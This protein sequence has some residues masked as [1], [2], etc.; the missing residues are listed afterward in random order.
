MHHIFFVIKLLWWDK[1]I[2]KKPYAFLIKRFKIIHLII[3]AFLL[4]IGYRSIQIYNFFN[5]Y[6]LNNY[7]TK[8]TIGLS[9]MY[10][11]KYL[12][13]SILLIIAGVTTIL[14][15][16]LKK[17]KKSLLYILMDVYYVVLFIGFI[18]LSS[19]LSS[20]E[21]ALLASTTARGIRDVLLMV[22][23]PQAIFIFFC[24]LRSIG[25]NIKQFNFAKDLREIEYASA[26]ADEVEISINFE[27]YKA[28]RTLR[29]LVREI[30]YYVKENKF[31]VIC[32]T[33]IIVVVSGYYM[34]THSS[35]SY[36]LNYGV[37]ATFT[38][39]N[40]KINFKE[41]IITNLNYKGKI[42]NDGKYYLVL[43]AGISNQSGST[44]NLDYRSF[45]LNVGSEQIFPSSNYVR[46]FLD[47]DRPNA[48]TTF[49]SKVDT[50]ILLVYELNENQIK[51]N[52]KMQ[53]YNGVVYKDGE[54][55]T[56]NIYVK[57]KPKIIGKV[58][59]DKNYQLNNEVVFK[60]TYL[61][62][63]TLKIEN[64]Q[65][66]KTYHYKY[67]ICKKDECNNYDDMLSAPYTRSDNV[68]LTLDTD[69]Y[70]DPDSTYSKNFPKY[71]D[72]AE[73]FITIKY[74]VGDEVFDNRYIN[75]TPKEGVS[76]MAFEVYKDIEKASVIQAVVNIRD[77]Q[78]IINLKA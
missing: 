33:G 60:D 63:S 55:I 44:V 25:L 28:K 73:Y 21:Y 7:T 69:L 62:K 65:I 18:Y 17:K 59:I 1:V 57:I 75:V 51:K 8:I 39:N 47:F 74:R 48:Q 72:F 66:N 70:L 58:Q 23:V 41:S 76:F 29:R 68:I 67:E 2:L 49:S 5:E 78:Y 12:F 71:S 10:T 19:V 50:T 77:R 36:D 3:T 31:I 20:F 38:Y 24:A 35:G 43:Q 52:M 15:F 13:W 46:N 9:S 32:L 45:A 30:I 64:Y 37:G 4:L 16:L 27:G 54:S 61:K 6:V 11:P 42:I 22:L 40:L 34:F 53:I 56:K 14:V 26:D